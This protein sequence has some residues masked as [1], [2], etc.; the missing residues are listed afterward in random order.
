MCVLKCG[1]WCGVGVSVLWVPNPSSMRLGAGLRQVH[2]SMCE[3]LHVGIWPPELFMMS[4]LLQHWRRMLRG[5][6]ILLQTDRGYPS[7]IQ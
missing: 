2:Y 3:H 1:V 5:T 7:S 6:A 4:E